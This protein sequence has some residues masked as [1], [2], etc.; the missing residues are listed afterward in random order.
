MKIISREGSSVIVE[1]HLGE[2]WLTKR[3]KIRHDNRRKKPSKTGWRSV[4][5]IPIKLLSK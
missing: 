1:N 2:I 5:Y 4:R 3:K